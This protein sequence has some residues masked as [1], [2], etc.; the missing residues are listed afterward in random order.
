MDNSE[1]QHV[2][3]APDGDLQRLV[4]DAMVAGTIELAAISS[5]DTDTT[6]DSSEQ[7]ERDDLR[8]DLAAAVVMNMTALAYRAPE[9]TKMDRN[10]RITTL[11]GSTEQ[12]LVENTRFGRITRVV[13]AA[14]PCSSSTPPR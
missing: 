11:D 1:E 6:S 9:D 3:A 4:T 10:Q 14:R 2:V 13:P 7:A 12:W 5:T 8:E